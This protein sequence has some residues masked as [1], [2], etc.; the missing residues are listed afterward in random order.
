MPKYGGASVWIGDGA[1]DDGLSRSF[2]HA[3]EFP[4]MYLKFKWSQKLI[5]LL[6]SH[7]KKLATTWFINFFLH[8]KQHNLF[9]VRSPYLPK[10]STIQKKKRLLHL[11]YIKTCVIPRL[12][13]LPHGQINQVFII[14]PMFLDGK[15]NKIFFVQK[16]S[17]SHYSF[18][19]N[20]I[21]HYANLSTF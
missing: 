7:F 15:R 12:Y 16:I 4:Y 14:S 9:R 6:L 20:M 5:H 1:A 3:F 21:A 17:R 18:S 8:N 19:S 13:M 10:A 11:I 2:T